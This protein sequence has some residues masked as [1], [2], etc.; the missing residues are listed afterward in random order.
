MG[1]SLSIE[2]LPDRQAWLTLTKSALNP[3]D[4]MTGFSL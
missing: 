2:V 1:L 3:Q 4:L